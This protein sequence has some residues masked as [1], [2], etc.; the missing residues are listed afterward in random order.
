MLKLS[1]S[2]AI[3]ASDR[4][5]P[6]LAVVTPPAAVPGLATPPGLAAQVPFLAVVPAVAG[7]ATPAPTLDGL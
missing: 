5:S 6:A 4:A 2:P 3:T 1:T 7:P